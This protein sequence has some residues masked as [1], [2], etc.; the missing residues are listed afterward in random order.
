MLRNKRNYWVA[1]FSVVALISGLLIL[2]GQ[3]QSP[4]YA[5]APTPT[6]SPVQRTVSVT[7]SGTVQVQPDMAVIDLGVQTDATTASEAMTQNNTQMQSVMSALQ[8][9]GIPNTDIRT[10]TLQL[11]PRYQNNNNQTQQSNTVVGYTATNTVEVTLHNLNNLGTLLDQVVAAGGNNIQNIRFDV[12]NQQ[13]A[14]DQA[15]QAAI[16]DAQHKAQQLAQ[17]TGMKL[18][19]VVSI[20]ES[21]SSPIPFQARAAQ[22]PS[23]AAVPVSPGTQS[24]DVNVQVT[25][26][27]VTQ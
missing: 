14:M 27:L 10:T 9:A 3:N 17:L 24:V 2:P 11:Y 21:S 23:A 18:G 13:V 1:L 22:A 8:K 19:Q 20:N 16:N 7:G 6:Q 4:V 15:R 12:A 26:E 5:Q 25:W